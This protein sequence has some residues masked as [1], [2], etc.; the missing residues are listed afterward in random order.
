MEIV[1]SRG[2]SQE[3]PAGPLRAD[4]EAAAMSHPNEVLIRKGYDAFKNN[5]LE[6]LGELFADDIVWHTAGDNLISGD[7]RGKQ[8]VFGLFGRL[9]EETDG[10]FMNE[11][12]DA[13]GSDEHAVALTRIRGQRNGKTLETDAVHVMHIKDGKATESWVMSK[14]QAATDAFWS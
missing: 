2:R 14:D 9:F 11:V 4:G 8:E 1:R 7:T 12:H 3:R 13:F 10:T 6:T 5:D